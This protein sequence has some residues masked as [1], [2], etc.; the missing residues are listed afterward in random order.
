MAFYDPIKERLQFV[1]KLTPANLKK[2][3]NERLSDIVLKEIA[4]SRTRIDDL[5]QRYPSAG[6]REL[7]QR[8]LID[9]KK[10]LASM[11]G[12]VSGV[13]GV[14]SVPADLLVMVWLQIILLVDL[15]TLYK[16]NLKSERSRK[17]LLDLFGY[18]NGIGPAQRASPKVLGKLVAVILEKGGMNVFGRAI[19]LIAAPISA[20]LNNIHIQQVGDEAIRHYDG[21]DKVHEKSSARKAAGGR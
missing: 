15:A 12:G 11:V 1:K 7:A 8:R 21:F 13:F 16:V 6:P 19:P 17:E 4:R 14:V 5:T 3:A 10:G 20:Y 9:G 18:A 2:L